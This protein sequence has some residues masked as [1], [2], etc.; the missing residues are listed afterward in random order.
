[1]VG[2][3]PCAAAGEGMTVTG[4]WVDHPTYGPQLDGGERGAPHAG[5]GGTGRRGLSRPPASSRAWGPPRPSGWWTAS[6]PIPWRVIEEEPERLADPQGHH[7]Q[8]GHGAR[9]PPSGR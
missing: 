4:V 3:I 1:M 2:C 5:D 6:A 7:R 8:A 9:P